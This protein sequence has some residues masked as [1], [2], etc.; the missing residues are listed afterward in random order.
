M[1]ASERLVKSCSSRSFGN[2]SISRKIVAR[3]VEAT[4]G[5]ISKGSLLEQ[6]AVNSADR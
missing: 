5:W 2:S 4:A 1:E 3:V 6:Y